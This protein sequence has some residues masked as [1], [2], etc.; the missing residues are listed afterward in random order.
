MKVGV[1]ADHAGY[2][3]KERL[4][5]ELLALGH[6]VHDFGTDTDA[7]CDYPDFAFLLARALQEGQV[8]RG[9]WV[10]ATGLGGTLVA[11]RFNGVRAVC[12]SEPVTARYSRSHN[13]T[14][15]L[16]LGQRIIGEEVALEIVRTWLRTEFSGEERHRRR[17]NK[18][19][20][21]WGVGS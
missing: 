21:G 14:N 18:I 12:C 10:C 17:L 2:R 19:V 6:Q 4:K 1:A 7:A 8:E 3:I 11:G 9:I 5:A 13:N 15:F 20:S 16:A